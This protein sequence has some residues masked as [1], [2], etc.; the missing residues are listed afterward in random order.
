VGAHWL[1][2]EVNGNSLNG[3]AFPV[4]HDD[5][6]RRE[7]HGEKLEGSKRKSRRLVT[8]LAERVAESIDRKERCGVL[9]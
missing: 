1:L 9:T 4:S 7:N 3:S 2:S 5:L 6:R 8:R